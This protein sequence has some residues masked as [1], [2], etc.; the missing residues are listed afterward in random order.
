M[1]LQDGELHKGRK[2]AKR[3]SWAKLH[4]RDLAL[5]VCKDNPQLV[6]EDN[7]EALAALFLG[8]VRKNPGYLE[9]ISI[10]I[11]ANVKA[12][13]EARPYTPRTPAQRAS[14]EKAVENSVINKVTARVLM[15]FRMP[16]G[17][18]L[19]QS[20]FAECATAGGWLTKV[21]EFGEPAEIVGQKLSEAQ[22]RRLLKDSGKERR[23]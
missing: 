6:E 13:L 1:T 17:K 2:G 8:E 11:M 15:K 20:T 4:F 5:Q 22:L 21:S 23:K 12:S 16:N 19:E 3:S 9:S 7:I 10:Y 14:M 18:T